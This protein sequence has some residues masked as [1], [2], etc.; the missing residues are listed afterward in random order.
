[1]SAACSRGM[2][3]WWLITIARMLN[4]CGSMERALIVSVALLWKGSTKNARRRKVQHIAQVP[5]TPWS[6]LGMAH[7][8]G[9]GEHSCEPSLVLMHIQTE[10][11][12][13]IL[14]QVGSSV[15]VYVCPCRRAFYQASRAIHKVCNTT[16]KSLWR[17]C[18]EMRRRIPMTTIN[19]CKKS[20]FRT[21]TPRTSRNSFRIQHHST[22]H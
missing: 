2:Q 21:L 9:K 19:V 17:L 10:W 13:K 5:V 12:D 18:D 22:L 1:M 14:Q 3:G 15:H 4:R 16:H 20:E 7:G 11:N 8:L 6:K